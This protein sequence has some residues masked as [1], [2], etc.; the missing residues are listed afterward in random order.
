MRLLLK[1]LGLSPSSPKLR[2]LAS[3]AS[4]E[5]GDPDSAQFLQEFF[6]TEA[7]AF[8]IIQGDEVPPGPLPEG[9]LPIQPFADLLPPNNKERSNSPGL[10]PLLA[11]Q[12]VFLAGVRWK[13]RSSAV[14]SG[15]VTASCM[16]AATKA[17]PGRW[18]FPPLRKGYLAPDMGRQVRWRP[19]DYSRSGGPLAPRRGSAQVSD[20][21][22][23]Q[24][25]RGT[26]GID[27]SAARN[28]GRPPC[29]A[30]V[31]AFPDP[32]CDHPPPV[33]CWNSSIVTLR[34]FVFWRIPE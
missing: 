24:K 11:I 27:T 10:P 32:M 20:P 9:H 12:A 31:S 4:L 18:R 15:S 33:G 13:K 7:G 34:G 28:R 1:R 14:I 3:S 6:G 2:I 22:I 30:A 17:G 23:L 25:C 26:L 29:R 19:G 21:P 16:P 5:A 8:E